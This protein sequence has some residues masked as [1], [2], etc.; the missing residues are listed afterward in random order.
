MACSERRHM[1]AAAP[2]AGK[3]MMSIYLPNYLSINLSIYLS[4]Y[5]STYLSVSPSV[6]LS[7][8]LPSYL[9]IYR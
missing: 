7:V 9:S 5:L 1:D 4:I 2:L 6:Y 3:S 8:Y